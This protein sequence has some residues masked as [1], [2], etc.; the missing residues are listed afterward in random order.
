VEVASGSTEYQN[1]AAE[2]TLPSL[3]TSLLPPNENA[4]DLRTI[5]IGGKK[6]YVLRW[7]TAATANGPAVSEQLTLDATTQALPI[8][9]TTEAGGF[10]QTVTL[11]QW[12]E[13][14]TVTAP[15][16]AVPY[17]SVTG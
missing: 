2:D 12:G 8:S 17:A 3:P 6:V 4:S 16:S 13:A 1:L 5:T 10:R 7:S 14:L 15:P 11:S 9:E